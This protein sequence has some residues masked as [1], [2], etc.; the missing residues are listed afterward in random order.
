MT[1]H[2]IVIIGAGISG[3]VL[4]E[5][6]A[7]LGKRVLIIEKRNHIAGNCFDEIEPNTGILVSRYGAHIFHTNYED[8]YEYVTKYG[9]WYNFE[10][11]VLSHINGLNVPVPVNII[12]VNR[13]FNENIQ[14]EE[15]MINWLSEHQSKY[16]YPKNSEEAALNRVGME[17]YELM[18]KNYTH[19][20]WGLWPS[21]LDASVMQR[22][23]VRS[24]YDC[25]YFEDK[26]QILPQYGYTHIF[27]KI[28]DNPLIEIRLNTDYLD[29]RNSYIGFEKLFFTGPIDA[30]FNYCHGERLQYRSLKFEYEISEKEYYQENSV[31]NYPSEEYPFTR[32]IEYKH[33]ASDKFPKTI[34]AKE[35]SSWNGDPYYP[36]P[37]QRNREIYKLYQSDAINLE[38]QNIFF[39]GRLGSY[40][41]LNMDQAIKNALD[42]F[43][44][45][46]Y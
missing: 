1:N 25:R 6:Y 34:I 2:D 24:N 26:Y 41:Y 38:K 28:L 8:V 32:I 20:Q 18:F 21:E 42:L 13:L 44:K 29:Y 3:V 35:Y 15:G 33:F 5:R 45:L 14:N 27:N 17:L 43:S 22:I 16:E 10:H 9:E 46:E 7:S 30:Y 19:K 12:T 31:I 37:T 11:K 36:V 40:K 23:P 4:A 39:A